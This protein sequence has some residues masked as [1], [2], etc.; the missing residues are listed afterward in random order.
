MVYKTN[1]KTVDQLEEKI[2]QVLTNVHAELLR[3]AIESNRKHIRQEGE[4]FVECCFLC[5][6]ATLVQ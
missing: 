3:K 2:R 4:M 5:R 6:A 1:P